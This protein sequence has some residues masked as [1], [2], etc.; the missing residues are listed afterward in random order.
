MKQP[1]YFQMV[2]LTL[3]GAAV[4][5]VTIAGGY[6]VTFKLVTLIGT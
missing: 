1:S 2:I 4:G 6:Y 5:V 3:V